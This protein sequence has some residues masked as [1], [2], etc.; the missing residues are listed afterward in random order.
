MFTH[1]LDIYERAV[2]IALRELSQIVKLS[3]VQPLAFYRNQTHRKAGR[4]KL[5]HYGGQR[6]RRQSFQIG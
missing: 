1:V 2:R 3:F 4:I 6:A 5:Q